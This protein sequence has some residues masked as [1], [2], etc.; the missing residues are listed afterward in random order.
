MRIDMD[1]LYEYAKN[2]AKIYPKIGDQIM[3]FFYIAEMEIEDGKSETQECEL[4]LTDIKYL[5][6]EYENK[7]PYSAISNLEQ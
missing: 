7:C 4:A 1:G 5:I 3:D 2:M 6:N